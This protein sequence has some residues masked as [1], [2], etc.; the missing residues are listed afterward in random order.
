MLCVPGTLIW[1]FLYILCN[2]VVYRIYQTEQYYM[3][4]M[5]IL[6]PTMLGR[7]SLTLTAES[8]E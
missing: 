1:E 2:I 5:I 7:R 4:I 3:I 8:G 6:T